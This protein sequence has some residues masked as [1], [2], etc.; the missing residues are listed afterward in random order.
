MPNTSIPAAAE[1]VAALPRLMEAYWRHYAAVIEAMR[2]ADDAPRD[3]RERA[4]ADN[5]QMTEGALL[6]GATLAICSFLPTFIV[7]ARTKASF[8][9]NLARENS[10]HLSESE[11]AALLSSLPHLISTKDESDDL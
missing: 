1:G 7:D 6:E 11:T 8:L 5:R 3:S 9:A 4:E 10:G 2:D